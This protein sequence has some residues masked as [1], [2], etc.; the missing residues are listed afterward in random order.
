MS[1]GI[2]DG[3]KR[4]VVVVVMDGIGETANKTGNAVANANTP[5]LDKLNANYPKFLL[6]AHGS[7]PQRYKYLHLLYLRH[8]L[9]LGGQRRIHGV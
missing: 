5:T 9:L 2:F 1:K 8:R 4:P 6:Q 3:E 7:Y